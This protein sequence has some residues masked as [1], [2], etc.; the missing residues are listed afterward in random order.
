MSK[1]PNKQKAQVPADIAQLLYEADKRKG[2]PE[3]TMAALMQQ[4]VGGQM[5]KFLQDPTA[6]HYELNADGKRIAGHT[7][8][9][10]T[11]FGPLGLLEPTA[12][13]PGYG[14]EPLKDKSIAEQVRFASDYLAA[15]SKNA[16]GLSAGL[17]GY[18]EGAKY[19]AQVGGRIGNGGKGQV[20]PPQVE[21]VQMAAAPVV[22]PLEA[23]A[24]AQ[25]APVPTQAQNPAGQ[26]E[27]SVSPTTPQ[28]VGPDPWYAFQQAVPRPVQVAD[29]SGYGAAP[30]MQVPDF[31]AVAPTKSLVPNFRAF[32]GWR[33]RV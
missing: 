26:E 8:K 2:F 13:K 10:S 27:G 19:A 6:Y 25:A 11:A 22:A 21:P 31:G 12:A 3:G 18:G 16:G 28:P 33:G 32:A 14:V 29:L 5:G 4:E 7:G 30:Q 15:R 1:A 9:V 20:L 23:V 24:M 17:A